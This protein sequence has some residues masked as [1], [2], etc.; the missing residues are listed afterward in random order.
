V[1]INQIREVTFR[2]VPPEGVDRDDG[3]DGEGEAGDGGHALFIALEVGQPDRLPFFLEEVVM[4]FKRERASGP[5]DARFMLITVVGEVSA[6]D[7]ALA[8]HASIANDA[9]AR[10]LLGMLRQADVMQGN[11][12]GRMITQASLLAS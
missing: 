12:Q 1:A 2:R 5:P 11:A 8:W 9:P 10:A 6:E 3:G 7:F 4:R